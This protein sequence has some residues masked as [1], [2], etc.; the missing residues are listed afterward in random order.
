M[1]RIS[2]VKTSFCL[3]GRTQSIHT[4]YWRLMDFKTKNCDL[5]DELSALVSLLSEM[6]WSSLVADLLYELLAMGY[7][8]LCFDPLA[9]V[10]IYHAKD[11]AAL[12]G[13]C[14]YDL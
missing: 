9:L 13:L 8:S 1:Y 3:I 7:V 4:H 12:F 10:P 5:Q 2:L 6:L 14:N 11:T